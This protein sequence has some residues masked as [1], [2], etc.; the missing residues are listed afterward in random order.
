MQSIAPSHLAWTQSAISYPSAIIAITGII[1]L[2]LNFCQSRRTNAQ[3]RAAI[4]AK[5]LE[6]FMDDEDMKAV[7]YSIEY[8]TFDYNQKTFHSS[9]EE[10]QLDKLLMHFSTAALAWQAGLLKTEDLQP[11]QYFV[12]RLL[13]D[14]NVKKY[15]SFVVDWSS[16]C[17]LGE[18]PYNALSKM[19]SFLEK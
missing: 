8:S 4:V 9:T 15:M 7:F 3:A 12:R 10:R 18:H 16:K 6:R 19:G 17:N 14:A 2:G 13:G 11:L 1:A 5:C